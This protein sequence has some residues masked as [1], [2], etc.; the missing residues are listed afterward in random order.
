[1]KST[2]YGCSGLA[3]EA[4]RGNGVKSLKL[5]GKM[6]VTARGPW[7]PLQGTGGHSVPAPRLVT[8]FEGGEALS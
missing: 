7:P 1:M 5:K 4:S 6:W 2:V 3:K 8:G